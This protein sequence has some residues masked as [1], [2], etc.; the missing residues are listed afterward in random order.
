MILHESWQE[1]LARHPETGMGYQVVHLPG[2]HDA[3]QS[4]I[5]VNGERALERIPGV[6]AV[7]ED[8]SRL[9]DGGLL[10]ALREEVAGVAFRVLSRAEAVEA[11]ILEPTD[12]GPADAA[13]VEASDA[14]ERFLRF[15]AFDNDRRILANGAVTPGTYVTTLK[16]GT[17]NVR[18][19]MDAVRRYA[20]PNPDPAVHRYL[21]VPPSI[22]AVRRGTVQP[23]FGQPGGGAEVIFDKGASAGTM[24]GK[25]QLPAG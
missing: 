7:R 1:A 17:A 25:D 3:Q 12:D 15:S 11:G 8:L 21:L 2:V 13:P 16:D 24:Q 5:V 14:G 9:A 4:A 6:R 20:L 19:G 10:R 18:N 22:V 23:A